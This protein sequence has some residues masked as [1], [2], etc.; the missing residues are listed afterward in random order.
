[1]PK[2]PR[3]TSSAIPSRV[4]KLAL[5]L[6][7]SAVQEEQLERT[8]ISLRDFAPAIIDY[9]RN[10]P[11]NQTVPFMLGTAGRIAIPEALLID[12]L[13]AMIHI[14]GDERDAHPVAVM[15]RL[16][17]GEPRD[18]NTE[19]TLLKYAQKALDEETGFISGNMLCLSICEGYWNGTIST[20]SLNRIIEIL[21]LVLN[22][23]SISY[24]AL[25]HGFAGVE[26]MTRCLKSKNGQT[27]L[28][29]LTGVAPGFF[30]DPG[31]VMAFN[32]TALKL[33]LPVYQLRYHYP[34]LERQVDALEQET[35]LQWEELARKVSSAAFE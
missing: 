4:K 27:V 22:C 34:D 31:A 10:N 6:D 25:M 24:L 18:R 16:E 8:M 23:S 14:S 2:K 21:N 33:H 9:F 35:G 12:G 30:L 7:K 29:C 17:N 15:D 32:K 13:Q 3:K 19:D 5:L 26:A 20:E 1:M 28:A 11:E